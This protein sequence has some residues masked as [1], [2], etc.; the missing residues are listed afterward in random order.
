MRFET[1]CKC[2]LMNGFL[3]CL[4]VCISILPCDGLVRDSGCTKS[5]ANRELEIGT[6]HPE[7]LVNNNMEKNVGLFKSSVENKIRMK[8]LYILKINE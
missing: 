2:D 5:R 3:M 1:D 8:Y 4:C 6:S 7:H